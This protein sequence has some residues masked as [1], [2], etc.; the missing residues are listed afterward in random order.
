MRPLSPLLFPQVCLVF[1]SFCLFYVSHTIFSAFWAWPWRTGVR[2][3]RGNGLCWVK[4]IGW[5]MDLPITDQT[6]YNHSLA[7]IC[8]TVV[9]VLRQGWGE[10]YWSV[11][12]SSSGLS[13]W[14]QQ[15]SNREPLGWCLGF[16]PHPLCLVSS[17]HKSSSQGHGDDQ[18]GHGLAAHLP[19]SLQKHFCLWHEKSPRIN[20]SSPLM[21]QWRNVP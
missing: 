7:F 6:S 10:P 13:Q 17:L 16:L 9:T 5:E 8:W 15:V 20:H 18:L 2:N 12:E 14:H 3:N 19:V 1:L 11:S 21:L 4:R